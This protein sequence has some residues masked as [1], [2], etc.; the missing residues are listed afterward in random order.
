MDRIYS[1]C[2]YVFTIAIISLGLLNIGCSSQSKRIATL[3]EKV[4]RLEKER[5]TGESTIKGQIDSGYTDTGQTDS[6]STSTGQTDR[7]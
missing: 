2:F 6:D 3:E 1:K 4:E 5:L 7:Y